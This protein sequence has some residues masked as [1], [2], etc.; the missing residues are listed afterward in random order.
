MRITWIVIAMLS[1]R[2]ATATADAPFAPSLPKPI[3]TR[4]NAF[5][6]PFI[7]DPAE[8]GARKAVEVQLHVSENGGPW[9]LYA[10]A[11]P[12]NGSIPFRGTRDGEYRFMVRTKD[13]RGDLQPAGPPFPELI[14]IMDTD[15]PVLELLAERGSDAEVRAR[16]RVRDA[17]LNPVSLRLEY[18]VGPD[19]PWLPVAV[20][21]PAIGAT[22]SARE[23]TWVPEA[24]EITITVRAEVSDFAGNIAK[25][26]RMVPGVRPKR[27]AAAGGGGRSPAAPDAESITRWPGEK[28]ES[29]PLGPTNPPSM[30]G[31]FPTR[32]G[33][34][35]ALAGGAKPN[36]PWGEEV[37]PLEKMTQPETLPP[38]ESEV[39]AA[40]PSP[41]RRLPIPNRPEEVGLP[42]SAA[43]ARH[44]GPRT[45][46][47]T[48]AIDGPRLP[49]PAT[50]PASGDPLSQAREASPAATSATA[51]AAEIL[52]PGA[53]P[54]MINARRIELDYDVDAADSPGIRK[55]EVWGTRDGGQSWTRFAT[56]DDNRSPA[57]V[58]VDGDGVYGFRIVVES[59][60]GP[61]D[62][63][64]RPGDAPEVMIG[65]D[66]T[67]PV[68]RLT[69][70]ELG[71]GAQ[72]GTLSIRWEASDTMLGQRPISLF[73]SRQ[74]TG[75]WAPIGTDLENSGQFT[76]RPE[77]GAPERVYLRLEARDLAGNAEVIDTPAPVSLVPARPKGH[78]RGV[79]PGP[80]EA[81][82][83]IP[84][85][86]APAAGAA[87]AWQGF[88]R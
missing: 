26:Q 84:S 30:S 52:P 24:R 49:W 54:R 13:D 69:S 40:Q 76:W 5:G 75:P 80:T 9:K 70:T 78:I 53:Q 85:A 48:D 19:G 41:E 50:I 16:W 79:R 87:P 29:T 36:R 35:R 81:Q 44:P 3:Y 1:L 64:P 32:N 28:T 73:T 71:S 68:A 60:S 8:P 23:A 56:D 37:A 43:E 6:V 31:S 67:K 10:K 63:P 14:V 11:A 65:V 34:E 15:P 58:N 20:D 83:D 46:R 51:P 42:P 62:G 38:P 88:V 61:S 72:S 47:E 45:R 21:L 82:P 33:S 66:T 39:L 17:H 74:A 25:S 12:I 22:S 55:V 59:A 86:S 2:L 7:M 77:A 57:V 18:Q 27:D 4:Q